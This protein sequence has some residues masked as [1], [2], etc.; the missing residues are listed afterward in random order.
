[1]F[2]L[3]SSKSHK[4]LHG[5]FYT[6]FVLVQSVSEIIVFHKIAIQYILGKEDNWLVM[7]HRDKVISN[8]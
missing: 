5:T 7:F 8:A 6:E 3:L 4:P 2:E 1:M